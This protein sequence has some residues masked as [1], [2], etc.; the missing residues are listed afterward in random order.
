MAT[1]AEVR[2]RRA[3]HVEKTR[4]YFDAHPENNAEDQQALGRMAD[5]FE[6]LNKELVV[7]EDA[8]NQLDIEAK[9]KELAEAG[10][11]GA[12]AIDYFAD[13]ERYQLPEKEKRFLEG[14]RIKNELLDPRKLPKDKT[15]YIQA[16]DKFLEDPKTK[17]A[18]IWNILQ[19][20]DA[21]GSDVL[22]A[23]M[24]LSSGIIE[25]CDKILQMRQRATI[26]TMTN[27][28]SLGIRKETT[29]LDAAA[30]GGRCIAP[31]CDDP[32]LE[33]RV[34]DPQYISACSGICRDLA[35]RTTI[36]MGAYLARRLG[37]N[38][39]DKME[40]A[41]WI[42]SGNKQPLGVFTADVPG[43]LTSSQDHTTSTVGAL[44]ADDLVNAIMALPQ[45]VRQ[46]AGNNLAWAFH[47]DVLSAIM[48][49]KDGQGQY[50][51]RPYIRDGYPSTL[52]GFGVIEATDI[53][54]VIATGNY[55]GAIADWSGYYIADGVRVEIER[56]V[57]I[58]EDHEFWY[59]RAYTDG[60]PVIEENFIRI[61]VQ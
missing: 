47:T 27:I 24:S 61:L 19:A 35:R 42:G 31:T 9:A 36:N 8:D 14:N 33:L 11:D 16:F 15:E 43:S 28:Q 59:A 53:P 54:G 18:E 32:V 45:C 30:W 37:R 48:L 6:V 20:G 52:L 50:I 41:Y 34:L 5:E 58:P 46:R 39:A 40:E 44:V 49:M 22:L 10:D 23:P 26:F 56:D 29:K 12:S 1:A 57:K 2:A 13:A 7:A 38:I 60:M 3:E 4:S 17:D 21:S 55:I 51:W 25:E